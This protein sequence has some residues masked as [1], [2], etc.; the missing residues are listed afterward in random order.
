LVIGVDAGSTATKAGVLDLDGTLLA[1]VSAAVPAATAVMADRREIDA[2]EY[3]SHVAGLLDSL[4]RVVDV[5]RIAGLCVVGRGDG[6]ALVTADG[7]PVGPMVTSA[8]SRAGRL[9]RDWDNDGTADRL[10]ELTAVRPFSGSP[11]ALLSWFARHDAESLAGAALA[12]STKDWLRSMLSGELMTDRTDGSASFVDPNA[13][14]YVSEALEIAGLTPDYRRLLPPLEESTAG[15]GVVRRDAA[16]AKGLLD[17][18]QVSVGAHD[19]TAGLLGGGGPQEGVATIIAGTFGV[20]A[21]WLT[22]PVTSPSLNTRLGPVRDSWVVRRTSRASA[23]SVNWARRVLAP[24]S[25]DTGRPIELPA[26]D[27]PFFIPYL[28]GGAAGRPGAGSFIG[29]R[30]HHDAATLHRCAL[31]GVAF[32]HRMDL[33][34]LRSAVPIR[35]VSLIGGLSRAPG[36]AQLLADAIDL[37]VEIGDGAVAGVRGGGMIAAVTS[38]HAADLDDAWNRMRVRTRT[39]LPRRSAVIGLER[40]FR[41]YAEL[42]H[43][44]TQVDDYLQEMT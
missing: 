21:A 10:Q 7:D 33:D 31:E 4:T 34:E 16:G 2:D 1:E 18:V 40:R 22:S 25:G 37:P 35:S 13:Q 24:D 23:S 8:D 43:A 28:R 3:A 42:A 30:D 11:A 29:L 12:L 6:L 15:A 17:G 44:L 36:W 39:I 32:M 41:V 27:A 26:L 5:S 9:V 20:T 19:V 38:G 14:R